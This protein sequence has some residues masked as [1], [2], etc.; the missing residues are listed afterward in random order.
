MN[1][2]P[3]TKQLPAVWAWVCIA[4]GVFLMLIALGVFNDQEAGTNA[5]L[6]VVA[7]CGIVF[8]IGGCM[9]LTRQNSRLNNLLAGLIC[10][11]FAVVGAWVALFAPPAGF[12]G[13]IPLLSAEA[14]VTLARWVFGAGA[15]LSLLLCGYAVRLAQRSRP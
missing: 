15:V 6:W 2:T 5:P 10:L 9:M 3:P 4:L 12:S 7:L 13:G 8:V 14:N 11:I 1:P